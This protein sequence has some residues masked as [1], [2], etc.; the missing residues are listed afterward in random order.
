MFKIVVGKVPADIYSANQTMKQL[1]VFLSD[2]PFKVW[3]EVLQGANQLNVNN[4]D[5][6]TLLN[7]FQS[8]Y[9]VRSLLSYFVLWGL[10]LSRNKMIFEGKEFQSGQV[11]HMI[12]VS[13]KGSWKLYLEEDARIAKGTAISVEIVWEFS[14]ERCKQRIPR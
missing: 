14:F 6:A 10:W 11:A 2:A 9:N 7:D 3:K 4:L 1:I 12:R 8:W 5:K 13:Y